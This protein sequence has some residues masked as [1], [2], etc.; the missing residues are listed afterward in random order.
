MGTEFVSAVDEEKGAVEAF[1]GL[2]KLECCRAEV[3]A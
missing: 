2:V 1:R 3:V